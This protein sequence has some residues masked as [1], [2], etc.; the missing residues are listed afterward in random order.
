MASRPVGR[1]VLVDAGMVAGFRRAKP[2]MGQLHQAVVH[3]HRQH[4]GAVVA[5]LADPALKWDLPAADQ[6]PFEADIVAQVIVCAPAG[7]VDGTRGFL[8]RA[9]ARAMNEGWDVV[10]V[11]DRAVPGVPLGRLRLD[12]ARWVWDLESGRTL[13]AATASTKVTK[14]ARRRR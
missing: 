9:A 8:E 7:A 12:G 1:L 14:S 11:T 2:S 4:P 5:L 13:D 10:A 3:L 6:A